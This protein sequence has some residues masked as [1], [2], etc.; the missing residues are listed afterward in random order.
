[1]LI[2]RQP[3]VCSNVC[4]Q[5]SSKNCVHKQSPDSTCSYFSCAYGHYATTQRAGVLYTPSRLAASGHSHS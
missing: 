3:D 5:F 2:D 1:M 4:G